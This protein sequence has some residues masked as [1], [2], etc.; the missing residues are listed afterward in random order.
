MK[1]QYEMLLYWFNGN[2]SAADCVALFGSIAQDADDLVDDDKP[3][4]KSRAMA[5]VLHYTM[6]DL[7]NN[8]FYRTNIDWLRPTISNIILAWDASNVWKE[9]SNSID[10]HFAYVYR[11]LVETLAYQVALI[12]GGVEH[13]QNVALDCHRFLTDQQFETYDEWLLGEKGESNG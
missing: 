1:T 5:R 8:Q 6:V 13:A 12:I 7:I 10:T 11:D 9:S 2:T 4:N 3:I